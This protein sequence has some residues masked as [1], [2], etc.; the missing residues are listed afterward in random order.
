MRLR[1]DEAGVPSAPLSYTPFGVPTA[2]TPDPF[3]FTGELHSQGLVYLRAR[4]YHPQSGTFT[5]RDPFGGFAEQPYSLH[6]YQYA[7]GNPLRWTDPSGECI[8]SSIPLVGEADA[9]HS[10]RSEVDLP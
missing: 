9:S 4:W 7:Y 5:S 1:V 3:G 6:P 2:E 8:P 10:G